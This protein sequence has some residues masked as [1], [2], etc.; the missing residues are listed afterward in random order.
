MRNI[1]SFTDIIGA[2]VV[3]FL[4]TICLLLYLDTVGF[5][6]YRSVFVF[7][8]IYR[9]EP[10]KNISVRGD[11]GGYLLFSVSMLF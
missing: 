4:V 5:A 6:N 9:C 10:L 7:K 8:F 3:L 1:V 11:T 2:V